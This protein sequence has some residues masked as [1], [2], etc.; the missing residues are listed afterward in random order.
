MNLS[1]WFNLLQKGHKYT[2]VKAYLLFSSPHSRKIA[3]IHK[4]ASLVEGLLTPTA[5][6]DTLLLMLRSKKDATKGI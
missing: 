3:S 2:A 1:M 5:I 6:R 4:V